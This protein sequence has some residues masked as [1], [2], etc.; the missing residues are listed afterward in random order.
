MVDLR[1][2]DIKAKSPDDFV[3]D[4]GGVNGAARRRGRPADR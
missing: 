1:Q 3:L 2:W 4:Q